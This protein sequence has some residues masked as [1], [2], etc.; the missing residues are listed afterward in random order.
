MTSPLDRE[1]I[2]RLYEAHARG[3]HAY[4]CSFVTSFAT[5][6]DVVHQVFERLLRGD[7]AITGGPISYLYRAVRN[8]SLNKIRD[9]AGDVDFEEGWLDSSA[10]AE[11]TAVE[12]QSALREL[13]EEQREVI[14]MHVWAKMSFEE[15]ASALDLS[16]NTVASRYRYGLSKLREQFQVTE[17]S[18]HGQSR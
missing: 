16:P 5:A 7:L 4:A 3:L 9:R 1:S 18:R 12:I 17:R 2:R 15:V 14:L 8:T 6:E 11:Q 10:G 13:P